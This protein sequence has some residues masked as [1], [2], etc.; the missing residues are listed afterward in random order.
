MLD[1]DTAT[2][3]YAGK[4]VNYRVDLA[5]CDEVVNEGRHEVGWC[6]ALIA[7]Q[8]YNNLGDNA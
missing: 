1:G 5:G 4:T 6:A 7:S 2:R 3:V 8:F